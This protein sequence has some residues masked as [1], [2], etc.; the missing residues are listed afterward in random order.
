MIETQFVFPNPSTIA[1]G[2]DPG[3]RILISASGVFN[4]TIGEES[5]LFV[6]DSDN[7][8]FKPMGM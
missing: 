4:E 3:L 8:C 6:L 5:M 2:H 1:R 7:K